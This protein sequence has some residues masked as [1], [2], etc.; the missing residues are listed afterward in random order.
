MHPTLHQFIEEI[1]DIQPNIA[2]LGGAS[3][4]IIGTTGTEGLAGEQLR[5]AA[6]AFGREYS[7]PDRDQERLIQAAK[8]LEGALQTVKMVSG[9][10]DAKLD[11]LVTRL[12]EFLR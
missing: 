9:V 12:H 7:R 4:A 10:S 11:T 2:G 1:M 8:T 6:L 5:A 3:S